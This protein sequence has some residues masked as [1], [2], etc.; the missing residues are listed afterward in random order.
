MT[1]RILLLATVALIMAAMM[2]AM[3][4]PAFADSPWSG[5]QGTCETK[6]GKP[7]IQ[8]TREDTN[9]E[10]VKCFVDPT[11]FAHRQ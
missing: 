11:Q 4:M 2:V 7:G 6:Q 5:A 1:R 10:K 8:F 3:A 9:K